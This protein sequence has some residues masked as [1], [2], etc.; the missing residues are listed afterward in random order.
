MREQKTEE[1]WR[2]D[3]DNEVS[4]YTKDDILLAR[5]KREMY[6]KQLR[7]S[8]GLNHL[9]RIRAEKKWVYRRREQ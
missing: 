5:R 7:P 8:E 4:K 3:F 2:E 9:E 6:G 1:D